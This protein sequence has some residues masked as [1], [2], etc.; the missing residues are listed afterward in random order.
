VIYGM[1]SSSDKVL[2]IDPATDE[3]VLVGSSLGSGGA[4]WAGGVLSPQGMIYGVPCNSDKVLRIDPATDETILVGSSLGSGGAKWIGG[5]LSPQGLIYGVP[6][7][8]DKV[9]RIGDDPPCVTACPAGSRLIEQTTTGD[10]ST[11]WRTCEHCPVGYVQP[12]TGST[13]CESVCPHNDDGSWRYVVPV[14][15]LAE[16]VLRMIGSSLGSGVEKWF[17]GVLSPQGFIYATPFYSDK[18]LRIGD[19]PPCVTACPAGS[20]LIEQTTTG[21]SNTT[22]RTCEHCPV[23]YV[24]PASDSTSE[25][26]ECPLGTSPPLVAQA[27][28]LVRAAN[29]PTQ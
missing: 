27:V 12:A 9:L 13:S 1:P 23:G 15:R 7:K 25:C 17:D 28:G 24:Q 20:R 2:R 5:V 22:W 6:Y 26:A 4:K 8:S 29:I 11:T 19:D 21:D 18:V 3:T 14:N 10:S 16:P